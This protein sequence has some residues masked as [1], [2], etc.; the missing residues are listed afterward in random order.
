MEIL[1]ASTSLSR[2][3]RLRPQASCLGRLAFPRSPSIRNLIPRI[4]INTY[5]EGASQPS[6]KLTPYNLTGRGS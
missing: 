4:N 3:A 2:A 1:K 5:Q 6:F